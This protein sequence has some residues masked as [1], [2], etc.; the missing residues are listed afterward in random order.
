MRINLNE[1][2]LRILEQLRRDAAKP[3]S[4]WR[5]VGFF[6]VT[7]AV[8]GVALMFS[9]VLFALVATVGL[10]AWGYLWW[11]LRALRKAART[12]PEPG[13][14]VVIEGEVIREVQDREDGRS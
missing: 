12:K 2:Q 8:V 6:F 14:S 11:R 4:V 3:P 1:E 13:S 9:V 7:V 10:V 5:K